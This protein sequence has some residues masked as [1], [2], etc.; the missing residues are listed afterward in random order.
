MPR[1]PEHASRRE[2]LRRTATGVVDALLV[3]ELV[4]ADDALPSAASAPSRVVVVRDQ[5]V[6]D[7]TGAR[8]LASHGAGTTGLDG[9]ARHI[10]TSGQPPYELGTF[11]FRR[12]EAVTIS[13]PSSGKRA[14]H[15]K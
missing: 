2:F 13:D 11:D 1:A 5:N 4:E 10:A 12:I 7:A 14:V 3:P 6:L 8:M 9:L 15:G